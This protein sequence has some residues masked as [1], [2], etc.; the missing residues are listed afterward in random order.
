MRPSRCY[1]Q[2]SLKNFKENVSKLQEYLPKNTGIIGIVKADYYGH[3]AFQLA[4]AYQQQ[5]VKDFAVAALNEA[6]KLRE[7]GLRGSIM[8]L[9]YTEK[10]EWLMASQYDVILTVVSNQQALEMAE[11]CRINHCHLKVEI[12]V[13]TGMRRIGIDPALSDEQLKQIYASDYLT[14]NGT[15]SHLCRADSFKEEDRQFTYQQN[16]IFSD[17]IARLRSLGLATGRTHLCASSGIVNYPEFQYDFVRPGFLPLGFTVGE[18][19]E[20]FERKPV[21][22]WYT[23]I[24]M[25]KEVQAHEGISYG[26]IYTTENPRK[27]ATL[28]IGYADGYPRNLSNRGY[29][30]IA[31]QKAKVVGRVCMDQMMVDVTDI[32]NIQVENLVTI[33]GEDHGA[34]ITANDL[35]EMANTIVD[36]IV[37]LIPSRVER[38][39]SE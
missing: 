8:V 2:I 16:K 9:G 29:V 34:E 27:I 15:F 1:V 24:E 23:K 26:H 10:V 19:T 18:I 38:Y 31:G 37:C 11:Y 32:E 39:Y 5:G 4:R 17:F 25:V 6:L 13:D 20:R 7:D 36:E 22:S 33:I 28:S 12:A 21:L 35:A 30:L 14:I 3:G